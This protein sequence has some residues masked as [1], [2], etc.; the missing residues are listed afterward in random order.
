MNLAT[1]TRIA[2]NAGLNGF[3]EPERITKHFQI[4]DTVTGVTMTSQVETE[5]S[6]RAR[7]A[8]QQ[9]ASP[10]NQFE[11]WISK[12]LAE[13]E[14]KLEEMNFHVGACTWMCLDECESFSGYADSDTSGLTPEMLHDEAAFQSRGK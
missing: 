5:T 3:P 11:V 2:F 9:G 6:L 10:A 4:T 13:V 14:R 8:W 1:Q 12:R 7:L